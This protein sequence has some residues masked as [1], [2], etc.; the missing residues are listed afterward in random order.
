M[1][2][3]YSGNEVRVRQDEL[4]EHPRRGLEEAGREALQTAASVYQEYDIFRTS[5]TSIVPRSSSYVK[6]NLQVYW[7]VFGKRFSAE[8][9]ELSIL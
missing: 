4:Y 7:L 8:V 1:S 5:Y 3:I 2:H 9:T 6:V